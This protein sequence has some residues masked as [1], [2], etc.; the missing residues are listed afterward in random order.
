VTIESHLFGRDSEEP[1]ARIAGRWLSGDIIVTVSLL[2]TRP[3]EG[4]PSPKG[5]SPGGDTASASWTPVLR[6]VPVRIIGPHE[7]SLAPH[8]PSWPVLGTLRPD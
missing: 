2:D 5:E 8:S 1:L 4:T 6:L 3:L 7:I